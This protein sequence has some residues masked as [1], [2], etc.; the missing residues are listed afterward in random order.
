MFAISGTVR[1]GPLDTVL[2]IG[3]VI[4][5]VSLLAGG[6]SAMRRDDRTRDHQKRLES[7]LAKIAGPPQPKPVRRELP[8]DMPPLRRPP[9]PGSP[10]AAAAARDEA[11]RKA[12]EG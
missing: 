9:K 11:N 7:L 4:A 8:P 2:I 6:N 3:L 10:E 1:P 5:G 12:A